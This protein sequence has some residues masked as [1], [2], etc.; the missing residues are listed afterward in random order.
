M[1]LIKVNKIVEYDARKND[2][3]IERKTF[4]ISCLNSFRQNV[5]DC[6]RN[7]YKT[8]GT[9]YNDCQRS[10]ISNHKLVKYFIETYIYSIAIKS[11]TIS[12]TVSRKFILD[13]IRYAYI[14]PQS[15]TNQNADS[16]LGSSS[17]NAQ[18]II[19]HKSS[20]YMKELL[21]LCYK[22]ISKYC[23]VSSIVAVSNY[24][25]VNAVE[26]VEFITPRIVNSYTYIGKQKVKSSTRFLK[27]SLLL[28]SKN[29]YKVMTERFV[30]LKSRV[31][32]YIAITLLRYEFISANT[33]RPHD[34]I[35]YANIV[36]S[37]TVLNKVF[38]EINVDI[39]VFSTPTTLVKT[40]YSLF[41]DSDKYFNASGS[42]F[43][44]VYNKETY[45]LLPVRNESLI[46]LAVTNI[47][48]SI[49]SAKDTVVVWMLLPEWYV[50]V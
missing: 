32:E 50:R 41:P 17:S 43:H 34:T 25:T 1:V 15:I 14:G 10:G 23:S 19:S 48:N 42:S 24:K 37:L 21:D 2:M 13:P 22:Q 29:N 11:F 38:R 45:L 30:E 28:L 33:P 16:E 31:N 46:N 39:K 7:Q 27:V 36:R 20:K 47:L 6:I 35:F 5:M 8:V 3:T 12:R 18:D 4:Y 49:K 9:S 26:C 40:W 44:C